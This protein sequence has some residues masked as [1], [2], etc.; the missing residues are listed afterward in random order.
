MK[1]KEYQNRVRGC[2]LGKN[3]GGTLGAPFEC[4]RGVYDICNYTQD[5]SDG[6]APND[7]LD[8]QLVWLNAAEEYG[9]QLNASI[10]GDY[11]LTYIVG[12]WSEYGAGKNNMANG[13]QPP[14]SGWYNN[15]NR[16]S[17]GAFIRSE[18]WACLMPGHPELAVKY[19]YEDAS[20]DHFGE[21]IY[22]EI[23]TA[24]IESAAFSESDTN[25]L[26]DIGLSYI[27]TD[28][29]TAY[30]INTVRKCYES[31]IS[32]KE[33]RK[34]LLQT[35]PC[36]FGTINEDQDNIPEP[37]IPKGTPGYDLPANIGLMVLGWLYGEG[38]FGKSICIAAGCCEDGDCTAA[39]LGAVLGIIMGADQL[40]QSWTNPIGDEIKTIS[41]NLALE[42]L[43]VPATVT[44]LTN[45]VCKLM[46]VFLYEYYSMDDDGNILINTN[47]GNDLVSKNRYTATFYSESFRDRFKDFVPAVRAE[48]MYSKT[49][50]HCPDGINISDENEICFD[51]EIINKQPVQ[52]WINIRLIMPDEWECSAGKEFAVNLDQPHAG[53]GREYVSI[54]ITPHNISSAKTTIVFEVGSVSRLAKTYIQIPLFRAPQTFR[55]IDNFM[56]RKE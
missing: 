39:T 4:Y 40:P 34:N 44:E 19:A 33:A 31:G 49:V 41:L 7:D 50:I 15:H 53:F 20:V 30:A 14:L 28:S 42:S 11:W 13:I 32:W 36:A 3:I 23:F 55:K 56:D 45:R 54:K 5:M 48:N 17:D 38:D 2:W 51:L 22:G 26:I 47:C 24:A 35:V 8:L 18:I 52:H 12:S 9:R 46:P 16:N 6:A 25:K 43:K 27:P 1:I 29:D 21:G 10:L 37:D